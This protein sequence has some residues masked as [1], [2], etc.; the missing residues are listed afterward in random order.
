MCHPG[1]ADVELAELDSAVDSRE[2]ELA[3]L[4]S[5]AFGEYLEERGIALAARP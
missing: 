2:E 4:G 5:Q 1:H 3:Y